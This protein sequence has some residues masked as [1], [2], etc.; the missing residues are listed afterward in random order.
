VTGDAARYRGPVKRTGG[1][2][3]LREH[4]QD[5]D[6]R[7]AWHTISARRPPVDWKIQARDIGLNALLANGVEL[8]QAY[9]DKTLAGARLASLIN[10]RFRLRPT[11]RPRSR[12]E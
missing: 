1:L 6:V 5:V 9:F 4:Q 11:S 2:V 7:P 8:D 12:H 3:L 10:R